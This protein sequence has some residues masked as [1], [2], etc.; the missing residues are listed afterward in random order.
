MDY[1]RATLGAVASE[2]NS[3]ILKMS[4]ALASSTQLLAQHCIEMAE[5]AEANHK[6]VT[7]IV[8]SAVD[9]QSPGD[10]MTLTVAATTCICY[11]PFSFFGIEIDEI[12]DCYGLLVN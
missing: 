6:C 3:S 9:I 4:M 11:F 12:L 1:G 2:A 8:R 5:I 7:S 10:L